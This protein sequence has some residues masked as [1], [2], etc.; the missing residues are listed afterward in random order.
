MFPSLSFSF[1]VLKLVPSMAARC[2]VIA[3]AY[4]NPSITP[5]TASFPQSPC[6][7]FHSLF[8]STRQLCGLFPPWIVFE[9]CIPI[10]PRSTSTLTRASSP[11]PF[12]LDQLISPHLLRWTQGEDSSERGPKWFFY[13]VPVS[14]LPLPSASNDYP[15]DWSPAF[16]VVTNFWRAVLGPNPPF[17]FLLFSGV[18]YTGKPPA[19]PILR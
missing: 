5:T 14:L 12:V 15:S 6:F 3:C 17:S 2:G 8:Y 4:T 1:F 16:R 10:W 7:F 18:L 19:F 9:G 13:P 11:P